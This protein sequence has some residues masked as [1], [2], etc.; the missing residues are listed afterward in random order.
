M[1]T[2]VII[3][4]VNYY[5]YYGCKSLL[6]FTYL[7]NKQTVKIHTPLKPIREDFTI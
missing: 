6:T 5:D 7:T 4:G 1:V 2:V 3:G